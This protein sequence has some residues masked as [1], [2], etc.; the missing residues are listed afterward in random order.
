MIESS[1]TLLKALKNM[2][3]MQ[4]K[5]GWWWENSGS[6]EVILG[7]ILTQNT[8][9][10]NV[11]KMLDS[12]RKAHILSGD[13][14]RDLHTFAHIDS[15]ILQSHINGLQR[16]KSSYIIGVS[17]AILGDF[18]TF[19]NFKQ[20]VD[21]EW[22]FAQ[23]GIGRE[24]AYSILNYACGREVMVVDK[25][26]YKLLCMLGREIED[27]EELRGFCEQ[28]IYDNLKAVYELYPKDMSIAQIFA[29]FHGKIVEFGKR[30]SDV[31][32][33]ISHF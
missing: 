21:F 11:E 19:S 12:M 7:S 22:L 25:Y 26:T 23:K 14:E 28:G 27:Y 17:K 1:F 32:S 24:S 6:F 18:D 15:I 9:W 2:D 10:S 4:H 33:L 30:K 20:N 5:P 31:K 16:Q 8:Q 29:R 13:C 3:L